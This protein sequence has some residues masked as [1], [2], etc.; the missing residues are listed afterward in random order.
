[1]IL[2]EFVCSAGVC[3]MQFDFVRHEEREE[4]WS[5]IANY[6]YSCKST[7]Q[8]TFSGSYPKGNRFHFPERRKSKRKFGHKSESE[9]T[10]ENL[11]II[12]HSSIMT[13][14]D[15]QTIFNSSGVSNCVIV[16]GTSSPGVSY[17]LRPSPRSIL[18]N[19]KVVPGKGDVVK[20][21]LN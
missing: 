18:I 12:K 1:M 13:H 9:I 16:P 8:D 4:E 21:P 20:A 6:F 11:K 5:G 14:F 17:R 7:N 3:G 15:G 2:N 10:N 19:F